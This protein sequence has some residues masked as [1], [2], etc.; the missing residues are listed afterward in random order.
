LRIHNPKLIIS[1][2]TWGSISWRKTPWVER[3]AP[4]VGFEPT[5]LRESSAHSIRLAGLASRRHTRLPD[6]DDVDLLATPAMP[7]QSDSLSSKI[8]CR[9][10][11]RVQL[12]G[13]FQNSSSVPLLLAKTSKPINSRYPTSILPTPARIS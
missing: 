4:G 8:A 10:S 7:P 9:I 12:G 11:F 2:R 6:H 3:K 13:A 5:R 1:L